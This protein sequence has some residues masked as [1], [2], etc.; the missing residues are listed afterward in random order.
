MKAKPSSQSAAPQLD[1]S[2]AICPLIGSYTKAKSTA[3]K[4]QISN[5][6]WATANVLTLRPAELGA[7]DSQAI[8]STSKMQLL[9]S[10]FLEAGLHVMG[11]QESR[12]RKRGLRI[13]SHYLCF[14]SGATH[15][16]TQC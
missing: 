1:P 16:G 4:V 7:T 9:Q 15:Q 3:D 12:V 14:T 5:I 6:R 2:L 11:A 8:E 13:V 10:H